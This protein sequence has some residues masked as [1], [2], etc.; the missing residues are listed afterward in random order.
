MREHYI[1][2]VINIIN[3]IFGDRMRKD[4]RQILELYYTKDCEDIAIVMEISKLYRGV[5]AK[6]DYKLNKTYSF[7]R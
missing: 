4:I 5:A 6:C 1:K 2:D 7:C 3:K